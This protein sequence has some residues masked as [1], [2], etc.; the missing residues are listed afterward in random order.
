M[1]SV[2]TPS[3]KTYPTVA[4]TDA[5]LKWS[6]K[7]D[8]QYCYF[9]IFDTD[10]TQIYSTTIADESGFGSYNFASNAT[11]L[12]LDAGVKYYARVNGFDPPNYGASASTPVFSVFAAPTVSIVTPTSGYVVASAPVTAQWTVDSSVDILS[13]RIALSDDTG[14]VVYSDSIPVG[15]RAV[16]FPVSTFKEGRTYRLSITVTDVNSIASTAAST[17]ITAD[18]S[19]PPA[20][21]TIAI[22]NDQNALTATIAVTFGASGSGIAATD[23]VTVERDGKVLGTLYA[24]GTVT[25]TLPPLGVEYAYTV[26]ALSPAGGAK[27]STVSNTIATTRWALGASPSIPLRFNPQA[28]Y[29][30][31]HGG[32]LYHFAGGGLPTF[33]G[34]TEYDESGTLQFDTVG[35][36]KADAIAAL[37]KSQPVQYLR[38]PF[39]HRWKAHVRP[40]AQHGMGRI[41]HIAL[42][43]RA[44]RWAE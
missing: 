6:W 15:S 42:D 39:G 19:A 8:A 40:S 10:D 26:T 30:L 32:E 29:S 27:I 9:Y 35:K 44:V 28:S 11:L 20:V 17:G 5:T 2:P 12:G 21:P 33:Y 24:D 4:S 3:W 16:D 34:T 7:C 37:L 22:T 43:W 31:D 18:Y 25:D 36:D 1:A 41:W 14:A 13:Q 23:S 38:D